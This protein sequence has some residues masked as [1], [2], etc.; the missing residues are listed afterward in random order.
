MGENVKISPN[1]KIEFSLKGFVILLSSL[2]ISMLS[3]FSSFYF[4]V[5]NPRVDSAENHA[6]VLLKE[7]KHA[8]A[9]EFKHLRELIEKDHAVFKQ[10]IKANTDATKANTERFDDNEEASE[11]TVNHG[12]GSAGDSDE[13]NHN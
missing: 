5:V 10:A 8:N 12:G 6:E 7:Y 13:H 9:K 4:M 2:I 1:T 3:I 11:N